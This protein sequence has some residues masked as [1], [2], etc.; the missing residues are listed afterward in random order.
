MIFK[1]TFSGTPYS[2]GLAHGRTYRHIIGGNVSWM[3]VHKAL[4]IGKDK[5][6]AAQKWFKVQR[7]RHFDEWPWLADEMKG[8][9]EGAGIPLDLIQQLNFRI[10]QYHF[11]GIG[12]CCSSFA[13]HARDGTVITG[14]TLDDPRELYVF[15]QINPKKGFRQMTFPIAGTCWANRGMNDAGLV[16]NVSSLPLTKLKFDPLKIYQQDLCV[17]IIKQTCETVHDVRDFC[18]K[19]PFFLHILA[20]D[21]NGDILSLAACDS[22]AN[23]YPQGT[24]C[25]TNHAFGPVDMKLKQ[26]GYDGTIPAKTSKPRLD[27]LNQWIKKVD[28]KLTLAEARKKAADKT[29]WPASITN[30]WTACAMLAQPQKDKNTLWVCDKPVTPSGFQPHRFE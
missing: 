20:V 12:H 25:L 27:C 23:E 30:P 21:A 15:C 3:L 6:A 10:W 4:T 16:I 13:A 11:Y 1:E 8:A 19:Y 22:G 14:G 28:G 7:E 24:M 9:S 18:N 29:G 17:R 26:R 2:I 5:E